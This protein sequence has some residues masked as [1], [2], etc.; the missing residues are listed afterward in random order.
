M[1]GGRR[2]V[3]DVC[4]S[5]YYGTTVVRKAFSIQPYFICLAQLM[6]TGMKVPCSSTKPSQPFKKRRQSWHAP[7]IP[8]SHTTAQHIKYLDLRCSFHSQLIIPSHSTKLITTPPTLN[9]TSKSQSERLNESNSMCTNVCAKTR[10]K[11]SRLGPS[12]AAI[13]SVDEWPVYRPSLVR[14]QWRRLAL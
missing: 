10:K 13:A 11:S 7:R 5:P 12:L 3:G 8:V 2:K 9:N 6:F 14:R 1:F 4:K